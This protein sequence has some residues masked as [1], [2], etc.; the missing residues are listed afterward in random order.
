MVPLILRSEQRELPLEVQRAVYEADRPLLSRR[1]FFGALKQMGAEAVVPKERGELVKTGKAVPVSERLPQVTPQQRVKILDFLDKHSQAT[2]NSDHR[3]NSSSPLAILPLADVTV[4]ATRCTACGMC[5]RFC[6]TGALKFLSDDQKFALTF[7]L[8]LCLGEVCNIC[9]IACPEHAIT[10]Q[11]DVISPEMLLKK[12][13]ATGKLTVC[14]KCQEPIASRPELPG[15]CF[16][17]RR[18]SSLNDLFE[19]LPSQE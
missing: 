7:E 17:C 12:P 13:V 6:P 8:S 14:Q 19:A 10:F 18:N 3:L 5:A 4:E 9:Q 16:A 15:S 2:D 11:P 1:G